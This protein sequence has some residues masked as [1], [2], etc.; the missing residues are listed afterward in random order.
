MT[1]AGRSM[2]KPQ[3]G[4]GKGMTRLF[5]IAMF[6]LVVVTAGC[7]SVGPQPTAPTVNVSGKWVG[8]WVALNPA[9]GSGTIEMTITQ[10]GSEYSGN[11][12]ITGTPSDPSGPTG[13]LVSGNEVRITRPTSVTGTLTVNGDNMSG[14]LAGM[15]AAN[16]TLKRQK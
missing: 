10:T 16:A 7:Q 15:I 2:A 3:T 12:L 13:G 6:T 4:G 14:V 11:L 9:M 1:G 5:A 8:T